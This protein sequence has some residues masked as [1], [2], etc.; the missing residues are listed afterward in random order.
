MILPGRPLLAFGFTVGIA[1][2]LVFAPAS[3]TDA[4]PPPQ[5]PEQAAAQAAQQKATAEDHKQMMGQLGI[6]AL[7]PGP[8]GREGAPNPANYD[9][10]KAFPFGTNLPAV[11]VTKNGRKVAN[12][13][14]WW[15]RRRP[16][17][18][19]DFEREVVGRVPKHVPKVTWSVAESATGTLG[20]TR[21]EGASGRGTRRQRVASGDQRRHPDDA[22]H[23][24]ERHRAGAGDD[25]VPPRRAAAGGRQRADHAGTGR[26]AAG[27]KRSSGRG[28]A[29]RRRLGLRVP[30]ARE[31]PGRQRRR[32]HQGHHRPGQQ[33]SAAQAR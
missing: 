17:I 7:R 12:A 11:L 31:H 15:K 33:G 20:G 8:S 16:E 10:A 2:G 24:G 5:T 9:E 27:R 13:N 14:D 4:Q 30:A 26:T 32:P 21:G 23:A 25:H 28:A 6:T 1:A 18:V 19:E 22:R 29:D 3:R